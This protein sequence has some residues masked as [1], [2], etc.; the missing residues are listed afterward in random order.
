MVVTTHVV[1]NDG[2]VILGSPAAVAGNTGVTHGG[3]GLVENSN[4][5]LKLRKLGIRVGSNGHNLGDVWGGWVSLD[6]GADDDT[7]GTATASTDGEEEIR[8]LAGI[9]SDEVPVSKHNLGLNDLIGAETEVM[10]GGRVTT[11]LRP[12]TNAAYRLKESVQ[13]E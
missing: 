1:A 11:T 6:G 4:G 9:C 5:L 2:C 7:V 8:V 10:V 13:G 3:H 12:A